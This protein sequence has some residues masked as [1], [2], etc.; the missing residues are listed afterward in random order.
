MISSTPLDA[1]EVISKIPWMV[2]P[3]TMIL[4]LAISS[5]DFASFSGT[6]ASSRASMPLLAAASSPSYRLP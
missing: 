3:F 1:I 6:P 5:M 4:S 2:T